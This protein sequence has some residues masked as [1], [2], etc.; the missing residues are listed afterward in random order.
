MKA[1]HTKLFASVA[2]FSLLVAA[3]SAYSYD[4]TTFSIDLSDTSHNGTISIGN[5]TLDESIS[6]PLISGATVFNVGYQYFTPTTSGNYVIG[7]ISSPADTV[8]LLYS[9]TFTTGAPTA[10]LLDL[11]DDLFLNDIADASLRTYVTT[12]IA[13]GLCGGTYAQCPLLVS[14]LTA[15]TNYYIVVS[16]YLP[17]TALGA[18][19]DALTFYVIG[20][21]LVGVGGAAAGGYVATASPTAASGMASYLD[22]HDSSGSLATVASFLDSA[23]EDTV[24]ESLRTIFPVNASLAPSVITGAAGQA[25]NIIIEKVG[26]VLGNV[27]TPKSF[28]IS[29]G[30]F[31]T[32]EWV[33]GNMSNR[34]DSR[35]ADSVSFASTTGYMQP[36]DDWVTNL[37]AMPY[38]KYEANDQAFWI[39]G[40]GGATNGAESGLSQGYDTTSIGVVSG[41]EYALN[42][43]NLVG[44]MGSVFRSH[45]DLDNH[46]GNIDADTYSL[47]IYGQHFINDL[48]LTGVML[49]SYGRYDGER[50]VDVGGVTGNPQSDYSGWGTST[51]I[52]LSKLFQHDD[53]KIEPFISGNFSTSRIGGYSETGGG[54]YNMDISADSSSTATSK[55][56]V[57]FDLTTNIYERPLNI[58]FKPYVGYLWELNAAQN[59]VSLSGVTDSVVIAGRDVQSSQIGIAA[60][61]TLNLDDANSVKLGIDIS[62]DKNDDNG[63]LYVGYGLK[64]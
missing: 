27:N 35:K 44:L 23:S 20:D 4:M 7:Q 56:G 33:F 8:I 2:V 53:V 49:A 54:V 31:I 47:G 55:M 28:S 21:A 17:G 45:I 50:H 13:S 18:P 15:G 11:D 25:T 40:V 46:A 62:R 60:E 61:T 58:K 22:G 51:T 10:N 48:K 43:N 38:K 12:Q 29:N 64:F 37:A 24:Y 34:G 63:I 16:T 59:N 19:T 14:N 26:T 30:S 3:G 57:T 52:A 36:S 41:Y 9:P 39:Q 6:L 1:S 32:S 42:T 5:P